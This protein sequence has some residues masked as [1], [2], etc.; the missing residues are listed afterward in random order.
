MFSRANRSSDL[1]TPSNTPI[2][3]TQSLSELRLTHARLLEEH[4]ATTALLR[5]REA[6]IAELAR[7]QAEAQETMSSLEHNLQTHQDQIV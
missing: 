2:S 5:Q 3:V 4:G 6:E 7:L 1:T